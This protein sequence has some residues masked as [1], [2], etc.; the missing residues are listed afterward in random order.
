M[1][2][3]VSNLVAISL[4]HFLIMFGVARLAERKR[5]LRRLSEHPATYTL[6]LGVYISAWAFYGT[7]GIAHQYDFVFLAYYFGLC[8]AFLL[9]PVLLSPVLRLTAAHQLT[10]LA[11]L[12]SFRFRST[13]AGAVTTLLMLV[14]ML[15]LLAMQIQ[16]VVDSVSIVANKSFAEPVAGLLCLGSALFAMFFGSRYNSSQHK[17]CALVLVVALQSFVKVV[18]LLI[19]GALVLSTVFGGPARLQDWISSHRE[20]LDTLRVALDAGPWRTMLLIFC[21]SAVVMP[22]MFHMTFAE[23]RKPDHLRSASWGLPFYLLL[24]SL[25]VPLIL[26]GGMALGTDTLP[27]Y[28]ALGIAMDLAKPWLVLLVYMGGLSAASGSLIV[29]VSAISSMV[30]THCVLPWHRPIGHPDLYAWL[31]KTKRI[32]IGVITAGCYG[33]YLCLDAGGNIAPWVLASFVAV[34]QFLPGVISVVY[35]PGASGK[36]LVAGML[37][38]FLIWL[39]M[40]APLL[41]VQPVSGFWF[42]AGLQGSSWYLWALLPLFVNAAFFS[43]ISA[44]VR[45][46]PEEKMAACECFQAL[47]HQTRKPLLVLSI[48]EFRQRLVWAVGSCMAQREVA[49]AI[50]SLGLDE[51]DR[52]PYSLRR[53][54]DKI[55]SNLC[56]VLGPEVARTAVAECLPYANEVNQ[57]DDV[58]YIE[59]QLDISRHSLTGLAADLDQLR[60][61]HRHMLHSLP[62]ALCVLGKDREIL[63]WNQAMEVL[64]ALP[65]TAM[66]GAQLQTLP[67]PWSDLLV[68]ADNAVDDGVS[69]QRCPVT[70]EGRSRVLHRHSSEVKEEKCLIITLEDQTDVH[71]LEQ[72]LMHNERLAAIGQLAAGVAHE[73]GNP[74][75][76]ID[77][78]AQELRS[79]AASEEDRQLAG[80]IL[81]QTKRIARIVRALV[82]FAHSGGDPAADDGGLGS[83]AVIDVSRCAHDAISLLEL[84]KEGGSVRFVNRC[85]SG[86]GILGS[87]QKITQVLVNLLDNAKDASPNNAE[88]IIGAHRESGQILIKVTDAG[89]GISPAHQRRVFEPFFTTKA[90]GQG[91]GLGMAL[92][93]RIIEEHF[94][95]ITIQ[96][97]VPETGKG[98]CV[99]IRLPEARA[100][101][102]AALPRKPGARLSS[103]GSGDWS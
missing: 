61:Y 11:D 67:A 49:L 70:I 103:A 94:G 26:W 78:L 90:V 52:R 77:C 23:N 29:C 30:V 51:H 16:A 91:T 8:G 48:A 22:D 60:V 64:T 82:S 97:P 71:T 19:L 13:T 2:F 63:V 55:E 45:K 12:F 4:F 31:A 47:D 40:M 102:E 89:D 9:A 101:Q 62:V 95:S 15:P 43:V 24:V 3:G 28:Y 66:L 7:V 100:A 59:S 38:G 83:R 17:S 96:S 73:I 35:W 14:A 32:L 50:K 86:C 37:G 72:K 54:R 6:A 84:N 33:L 21:A 68:D 75:T 10:S 79:A 39:V 20:T 18:V 34:L 92:V 57:A 69:G 56:S 44:L 80:Q 42:D 5:F 85:M 46:S 25:P 65:A 93:Y 27:E 1:T 36:G 58:Q 88:V 53:L 81:E 99:C 76:G 87:S 98:T 41:G 74:L